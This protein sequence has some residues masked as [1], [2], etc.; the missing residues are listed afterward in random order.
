[1]QH[2]DYRYSTG[3]RE[4]ERSKEL[5]KEIIAE[6]FPSL[7]KELELHVN[8]A[9]RTPNYI[10]VKRPAPRHIGV[11]LVKVNDIQKILRV[12]RKKKITCK[13][14]PIRFSADFSAETFTG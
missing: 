3:R 10:D 5:V 11:K 6:N 4:G 12:A 9:N 8:E 2:E 13:G 1:M 7:G 14:T